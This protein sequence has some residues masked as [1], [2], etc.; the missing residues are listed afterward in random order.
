MNAQTT[1]WSEINRTALAPLLSWNELALQ[2]AEKLARQSLALTQDLV[3]LGARQLQ[4]AGEAKEPQKWAVEE[5]KLLAEFGQK[6]A[7]RSNDYLTLSR[8]VSESLLK[9][10]ETTV[11]S[12]AEAVQPKA[13]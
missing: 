1:Q 11:K 13:A 5:G 6:L 4:L 9:W 3:E 8:E 12:T 7:S 10:G 2:T